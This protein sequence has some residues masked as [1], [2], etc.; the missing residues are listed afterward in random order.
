MKQRIVI[1][2]SILLTACTTNNI[3]MDSKTS[4]DKIN[5]SNEEWKKILTSE[6][7]RVLREHGTERAFTGEYY[8][9]H[10]KGTYLCAGCGLP[11]FHSETKFDSGTGWPSYYAPINDSC[12]EE[13][14]DTSFG[15]IRVEV[16]CSRCGG[17]MGHVFND[18]PNPTGLRYCINSVSLK[19][20]EEK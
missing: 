9:S 7:Y 10:E 11:L 17:H 19:F 8:D 6:Q 18:G 13:N 3:P 2:I 20:E 16:H 1:L 12:I 15:M 4:S 5:H 14:R